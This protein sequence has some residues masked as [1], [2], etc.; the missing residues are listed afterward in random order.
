MLVQL[1]PELYGPC[2]VYEKGRKVL[3][4]QVLRAIYGMLQA[5]LLWYK[6]FRH[7]L[8]EAGFEF[9]P[10]DP[11]VANRIRKESQQTIRFHVDDLMSSHKDPKINDE[12]LEWLNEMYGSL[13]EV[14]AMRGKVHDYLGMIFD[15]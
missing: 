3:Y 7:D 15:C 2:M 11:C 14:K 9:N 4:V 1:N 5:S 12:F 6:K 13:G 10:Y 8:E